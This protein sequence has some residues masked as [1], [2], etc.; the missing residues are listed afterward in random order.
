MVFVTELGA[1][2]DWAEDR[3]DETSRRLLVLQNE[4]EEL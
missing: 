4:S 1:T 3:W 2:E